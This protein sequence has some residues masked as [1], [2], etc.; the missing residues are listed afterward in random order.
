MKRKNNGKKI[1]N[2]ASALFQAA[3][4][5]LFLICPYAKYTIAPTFTITHPDIVYLHTDDGALRFTDFS[6]AEE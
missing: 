2:I 4:L 6:P 1:L 3:A 5:V